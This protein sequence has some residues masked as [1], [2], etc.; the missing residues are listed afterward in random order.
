MVQDS[1]T[2]PSVGK[3]ADVTGMLQYVSM[4]PT[5]PFSPTLLQRYILLCAD[6][7]SLLFHIHP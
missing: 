6:A 2:F 1:S 5:E 7:H 4:H 3:H